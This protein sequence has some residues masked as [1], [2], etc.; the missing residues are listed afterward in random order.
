LTLRLRGHHLLCL[1]TYVGKGYSAAFVAGFDRV[2]ERINAG[3]AVQLV[4]GPDDICA[5]LIQDPLAG[6]EVHCLSAR[7]TARDARATLDV[8]HLPGRPINLAEAVVLDTQTVGRLREAF[9]SRQIRAACQGCEWSAL[10]DE[11]ADGGFAACRL[12]GAN[13]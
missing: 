11:V 7:C 12:T 5:P 6:E 9:A 10:C 2:C 8:S 1:L 4:Q 13:P 3:E